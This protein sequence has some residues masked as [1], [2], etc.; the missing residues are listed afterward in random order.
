[1]LTASS[2]LSRVTRRF[3]VQPFASLLIPGI[4]AT[5]LSCQSSSTSPAPEPENSQRSIVLLKGPLFVPDSAKVAR[6]N[7][8]I[9]SARVISDGK[10]T[11]TY[12]LPSDLGSDTLQLVLWK[13][14]LKYRT[15]R[16]VLRSG[17][18]E[19]AGD[20]THQPAGELLARLE[21]AHGSTSPSTREQ[22]LVQIASS[23]VLGESVF[24]KASAPLVPG[25]ARSVLDS[26]SLA[27][28]V[29][30]GVVLDTALKTWNTDLSRSELVD[31]LSQWR[32]K[33]LVS[34]TQLDRLLPNAVVPEDKVKPVVKFVAPS[35]DT[36]VSFGTSKVTVEVLAT[37]SAGID[38]IAVGGIKRTGGSFKESIDLVVGPNTL[39]A[40]A[41][42]RNG[43]Q[44]TATLVITR[45]PDPTSPKDTV[46]PVVIFRSPSKDTSV[47]FEISRIQLEVLASDSAGVDSIHIDTIGRKGGSFK[48]SVVLVVGPN[49]LIAKAWDRSGNIGYDTL[50]ITRLAD[51]QKP[52][53]VREIGTS[54]T[55][56]VSSRTSWK[57]AW[58]VSDAGGLDSV[59]IGGSLAQ[60]EN[61]VYFR[62]ITLSGDSARV[63]VKAKDLAGNFSTDSIKITRLFPPGITPGSR[64]SY[65]QEAVSIKART[66][67]IEYRI[68]EGPWTAYSDTLRFTSNTK[69]QARAKFQGIYSDLANAGYAFAPEMIKAEGIKFL[70]AESL[71]IV[72]PGADSI[73]VSF[74]FATT[75]KRYTSPLLIGRS[76]YV[77]ARSRVGTA[78]SNPG[79]AEFDIVKGKPFAGLSN[80]GSNEPPLFSF[81]LIGDTLWGMGVNGSSQL[82]IADLT[83]Q[84]KP[85]RVST[86]IRD[87]ATSVGGIR[88]TSPYTLFLTTSGDLLGSGSNG[89]SQLGLPSSQ[90]PLPELIMPGVAKVATGTSF[91]LATTPGGTL[92]GWGHNSNGQMGKATPSTFTEPTILIASNV[93]AAFAGTYHSLVLKSDGS[94]LGSGS[95]S[96]GRLGL[97]AVESVDSFHTVATDV[98]T[99][100]AGVMF[101]LVVKRNGDAYAAGTIGGIVSARELAY[102]TDNV[103][104]VA[105]GEGNA[106]LIK[107]DSSLW[108]LGANANGRLGT[109]D[110]LAVSEPKQIADRVQHVAVGPRFTLFQTVEGRVYGMGSNFSPVLPGLE[111]NKDY[112]R[113]TRIPRF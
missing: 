89:G 57:V 42:D 9:D 52:T 2:T 61:G 5:L 45:L 32:S 97:G 58:K 48:D 8:V 75:W 108:A 29:A 111:T 102:L 63:V 40:K 43:N 16:I 41:W 74:D 59:Y 15:F 98:L 90:V 14:G 69:L 86:G 25:F 84:S 33:G 71:S 17:K 21:A 23:F 101:S 95:N 51:T 67:S 55:V 27:I 92:W 103:K 96:S 62:E 64:A 104:S 80:F 34:Q 68:G 7:R 11:I 110:Y 72:S 19:I 112:L 85:V 60:Q 88:V 91:T 99:A 24:G 83:I 1:M 70:G 6:G 22:V 65:Q 56:L 82:G 100:C 79:S 66:G 37:D 50:T 13:H 107:N 31:L 12:S 81:L 26:A 78:T 10:I 3:G 20:S 76:G 28:V 39:V 44:E 87:V 106:F 53:L 54:D 46:K 94:L 36:S 93:E 35:K 113:P 49:R 38:S 73:E 30:K 47:E 18:A 109:G 77:Y 4:L 105:C